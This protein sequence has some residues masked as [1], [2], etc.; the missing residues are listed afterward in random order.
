MVSQAF[1]VEYEIIK[2]TGYDYCNASLEISMS[3]NISDNGYIVWNGIDR[4]IFLYNGFTIHQVTN[5]AAY[6]PRINNN[7]HIVFLKSDHQIYFYNGNTINQISESG[8]N[9]SPNINDND[10]IVWPT[11]FNHSYY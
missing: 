5:Y 11:F 7:G 3:T 1:S 9:G 10:Y 4:E 6:E 2:I 8:Y